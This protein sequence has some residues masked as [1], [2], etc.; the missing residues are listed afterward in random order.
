MTEVNVL[1][2]KNGLLLVEWSEDSVPK[3]AWVTEDMVS[4]DVGETAQVEKPGAGVPQSVEWWRLIKL[5]K[6]TAKDIDRELKHRG[7]WT[8]A[9]L[10]AD[11][12]AAMAAMQAVYG[13]DLATLL[14]A[15]A[16]Y[17][18]EPKEVR[19]MVTPSK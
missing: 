18:K 17:E 16:E 1:R 5:N 15:A 8:V 13:L 10:Q 9:D 3:R 14:Q 2:R 6:P 19:P 4:D 7:I 12:N 11:P